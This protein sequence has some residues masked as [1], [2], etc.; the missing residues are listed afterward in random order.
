MANY[1]NSQLD[2]LKQE[3]YQLQQ[4]IEEQNKIITNLEKKSNGGQSSLSNYISEIHNSHL[5]NDLKQ[6]Q[7]LGIMVFFTLVL[8]IVLACRLLCSIHARKKNQE[9]KDFVPEDIQ[10]ISGGDSVDTQLDLANAYIEI[11]RNE[12][13]RELLK[14]VIHEGNKD[15]R[16]QAKELL[17]KL[18]YES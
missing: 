2:T 11:A 12:D 7:L 10:D 6:H 16:K 9:E 17:K 14:T 1:T 4:Q 18:N 8:V 3:N 13:A 15:Q 5:D